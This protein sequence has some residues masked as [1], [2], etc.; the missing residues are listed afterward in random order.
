MNLIMLLFLLINYGNCYLSRWWGP[1]ATSLATA[2]LQP[3]P[4][5]T[6]KAV[7]IFIIA[8]GHLSITYASRFYY[9]AREFVNYFRAR[10]SRHWG[11]LLWKWSGYIN[12]MAWLRLCFIVYST[13]AVNQEY[14]VVGMCQ[15]YTWT[16]RINT[17]GSK[18]GTRMPRFI[19]EHT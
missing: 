19:P 7:Y 15:L 4:I 17:R 5:D 10:T 11:R 1:A 8:L 13:C 18:W 9:C 12:C 14:H 6:N 3:R 16:S 2:W